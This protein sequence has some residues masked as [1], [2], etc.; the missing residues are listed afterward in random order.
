M[1]GLRSLGPKP[2]EEIT[3]NRGHLDQN[4]LDQDHLDQEHPN[5]NHQAKTPGQRSQD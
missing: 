1:P 4:P 3:W 5:K 2:R